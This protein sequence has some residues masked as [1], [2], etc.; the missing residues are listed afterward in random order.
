MKNPKIKIVIGASFG[1]EGKG[2][3]TDYFTNELFKE[4]NKPVLNVRFNGGAQAGHTVQ[5]PDGIK[6]IFHHI[7]SGSLVNPNVH[8]FL[9]DTFILNPILFRK[10]YL[11]LEK[12]GFKP[13]IY[14]D[15]GCSVTTPWDM[16]LN[17][18]IDSK[19]NEYTSCGVGTWYTLDRHIFMYNDVINGDFNYLDIGDYDN[20]LDMYKL[21]LDMLRYVYHLYKNGTIDDNILI[22]MLK[23]LKNE[24]IFNNFINDVMFLLD[25]VEIELNEHYVFENY[26]NIVFEGAQG[27]L[28]DKDNKRYSPYLTSSNTGLYNVTN[29]LESA[30]SH[31]KFRGEEVFLDLEICYV[32]R[33]YLTRHGSGKFPTEDENIKVKYNLI[34]ETNIENE[35]QGKLRYGSIDLYQF[36]NKIEDDLSFLDY[37]TIPNKTS[38]SLMFT[39]YNLTKCII[40]D[41][42]PKLSIIEATF[43]YRNLPDRVDELLEKVYVSNSKD[44]NGVKLDSYIMHNPNYTLIEFDGSDREDERTNDCEE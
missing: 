36:Y 35:Y 6:H 39:Q 30:Y 17:Q 23:E 34:D 3:A 18:L 9:T 15:T 33:T 4:N 40:T 1:D 28:L 19:S 13:K 41:I 31:Y 20:G 7:G 27:L 22:E 25:H 11:E 38:V 10:E 43:Y 8:T 2:L 29:I 44:R 12:L 42:D 32:N 16:R 14:V 37:F 26:S 21:Q 24:T 5:T